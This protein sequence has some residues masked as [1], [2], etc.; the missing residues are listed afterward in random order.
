L[1]DKNWKEAMD[2]EY[3]AL[4]KTNMALNSTSEREKCN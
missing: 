2:A 3:M 1:G 4:M